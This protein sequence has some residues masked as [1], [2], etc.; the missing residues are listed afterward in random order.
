MAR[1]VEVLLTK[2]VLKLGNMG[3]VVR[4]A[5]GY[6]RNYLFPEELAIPAGQ[7]QKRQIEVLRTQASKMEVEREAKAKEL[8]KSLDGS[9]VQIAA[10]VSADTELFGSVGTREIVA[11]LEKR[12]IRVDGK[13]VHLTDKI[14]RLGRYPVEVRLH[15]SVAATITVEV[16]NS[17]PNA[18]NLA[19]TLAAVTGGKPAEAAATA[20]EAKP[21]DAKAAKD[22]KPGKD[23]KPAP[24]A[25]APKTAKVS[26]VKNLGPPTPAKPAAPAAPAKK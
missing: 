3:D 6:A 7:A 10:R 14:K 25:E 26:K 11:A 13:Q 23:A 1:R 8:R 5:P 24:A 12:G 9:T 21:A 4:V 16:T 2:D 20:P 18:P 22:A 17:D 15:K 19:E